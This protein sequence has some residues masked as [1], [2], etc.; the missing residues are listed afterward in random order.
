MPLD[1]ELD[2]DRGVPV[3]RQIYEAVTRA[4]ANGR[5]AQAE[6]LPT[7]HGLAAALQINPN[8]VVRAYK[9]LEKDGYIVSR[10]GR[11]TFASETPSGGKVS[12]RAKE[13]ALRSIYDRAMV[14]AARHQIGP[15]QV[16]RYFQK[17][18]NDE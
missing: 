16:V 10:R 18:L 3:Y 11:G 12:K 15:S 9:D 14:E 2:Y 13:K 5:L 4:L 7:I 6:K 17:A 1:I 8:T